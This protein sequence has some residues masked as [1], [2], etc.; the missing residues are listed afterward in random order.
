MEKV[1]KRQDCRIKVTVQFKDLKL[2][3]F[4]MNCTSE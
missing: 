3:Q 1:Y 2:I 4:T